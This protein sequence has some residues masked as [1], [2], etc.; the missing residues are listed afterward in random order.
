MFYYYGAK[1]MLAKHYPAP[2]YNLIIEPFAGSAAYSCYHLLKNENMKCIISDKDNDVAETWNFLLNCSENDILNYKTPEINDYAYDFLIKTC[3][4]SNASSKCIK[5]KY[6]ERIDKIFQIQ[7]RKI[8]NLFKIR[9]RITFIHQDYKNIENYK[10][11]WFIDPPYMILKNNNT[12]FQNG[13]GYSKKCNSDMLNFNELSHYCLE[14]NGEIIVCEKF[15]ANW[16]QFETFKKN[17]TS[18]NKIYEEVLFYK[19]L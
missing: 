1:N 5:M 7:K 15:G 6:T 16:L 17:K 18:L 14:R 8:L 12:V 10:G 9:D 19:Q 4:V 11:T 2:N 13:N 3:S